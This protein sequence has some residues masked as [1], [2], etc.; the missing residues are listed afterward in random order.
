MVKLFP[1]NHFR[2]QIF[3]V[4][5]SIVLMLAKF[6]AYTLTQSNAIL[7]DALES[8]INVAAGIF[9]LYSLYLSAKPKDKDHPY[10]HG[11]IEFISSSIEGSLI[12]FA[13]VL[14]VFKACFN[15]IHPIAFVR[16]DW[17]IYI[18]IFTGMVN[19]GVGYFALNNGRRTNSLVLVSGGKH[20]IS[21]AYSTAGLVLG[22]AIVWLTGIYWLDNILAIILGI[23]IGFTGYQIFRKSISGIMDE[24]DYK[25]LSKVISI[26]NNE[27]R[28]AWIDIHN[29][30]IIKYGAHLHIDC[31]VTMPW[32]FNVEESH[33]E[34]DLIEAVVAKNSGRTI[35]MFV[36]VDPCISASC[37][38]CLISDCKVRQFPFEQKLAWELKNVLP[39]RKHGL[40]EDKI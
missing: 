32:Y 12:L 23:I 2:I 5:V 22:L 35:E 8:I 26:L 13:G 31:H 34:I 36:H 29:M 27:R 33:K 11:K 3:I 6:T 17:G 38:H 39:D 7:T 1:N 9:S 24:T 15:F 25:M 4:V 16:I 18:S 21:D 40:V 19:Y 10:G 37:K 28:T 20:L 14:M 30:R